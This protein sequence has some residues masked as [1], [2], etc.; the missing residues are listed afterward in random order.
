MDGLFSSLTGTAK[1]DIPWR[2]LQIADE[3]RHICP[4]TNGTWDVCISVSRLTVAGANT[5]CYV[6]ITAVQ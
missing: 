4:K 1:T 6:D 3:N 5:S 2:E